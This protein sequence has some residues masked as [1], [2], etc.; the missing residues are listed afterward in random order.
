MSIPYYTFE[1]SPEIRALIQ[2]LRLTRLEMKRQLVELEN[3]P[4][5]FGFDSQ[6]RLSEQLAFSASSTS[7]YCALRRPRSIITAP[8]AVARLVIESLI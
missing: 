3:L 5:G 1:Q 4:Q 6:R 8:S 7:E 2:S